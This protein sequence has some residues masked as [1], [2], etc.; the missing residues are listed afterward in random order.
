MSSLPTGLVTS[1]LFVILRAGNENITVDALVVVY[2]R[3]ATPEDTKVSKHRRSDHSI[4]PVQR[5]NATHDPP[6]PPGIRVHGI[7]FKN[8]IVT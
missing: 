1:T 8:F 7:P 2:S 5:R 6:P 4:L 3:G